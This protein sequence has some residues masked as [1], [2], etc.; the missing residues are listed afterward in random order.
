MKLLKILRTGILPLVLLLALLFAVPA[1]AEEAAT[2][3]EIAPET[4]VET[5]PAEEAILVLDGQEIV[6]ETKPKQFAAD[7]S[8]ASAPLSQELLD[9]FSDY[10]V[11]Y[12][13]SC[14]DYIDISSLNIRYSEDAKSQLNS[15]LWYETPRAFHI[16]S[17]GYSYSAGYFSRIYLW[18]YDYA[19]TFSEV[20]G[21]RQNMSELAKEMAKDVKDNDDLSDVEKA[22]ILHDRLA[23]HAE[24]DV[25]VNSNY[26]EDYPD[27]DF[28]A[29]GP[30]CLKV[31][32][33]QGY[34]MAYMYLLDYVGIKSQYCS[35]DAL[36][37]GWNIVYI[38]G[39][40]YHVDVTW[41][42]PI[43]DV[44]G[45]VCHDNF[46]RST[47][48]IKYTGHTA[49]DFISTPTSTKYDSAYWQNSHAAFQ[50]VAGSMYYFDSSYYELYMVQG[51][52]HTKVALDQ[53]WYYNT[54]LGVAEDMLIFNDYTTLYAYE[55]ITG[56]L[57]QFYTL[58][59]KNAYFEGFVCEGNQFTLATYDK[60]WREEI[61]IT[62]QLPDIAYKHGWVNGYYYENDVLVTNRWLEDNKGLQY[63][64]E[65]G[66]LA[67]SAWIRDEGGMRRVGA[68]GYALKNAWYTE[69]DNWYYLNRSGYK[70]VSDWVIVGQK[71]YYCD[72]NG[73]RVTGYYTIDGEEYLFG[74]DGAMI[75]KEDKAI[76]SH[77]KS[78]TVDTGTSVTF[79]VSTVGR[80]KSYRWQYRK[81]YTWFETSLE[82][83]NTATLTVP[84]LGSRNGYDY[85]CVVTF[86]DGT[87]LYSNPA[88]LIV[89]TYITITSHPN[90]QV[91]VVGY[92]GQFTVAAEGEGLKYQWE[93]RRP[94]GERW[95]ETAMEGANKP[96]VYIES[97]TARDGYQY[98]CRITDAAGLVT[99]S[100][101]ATLRSLF[102]TQQPAEVFTATGS[103]VQFAVEASV[104]SGFTYQWQ[105]RRSSSGA[106]TNTTM[107]G[108]NTNTLTV[109]ATKARNGYEYRCVLNG[110]KSS[111]IESKVAALH[112]G[113]P[114]T[115]TSYT[116]AITAAVGDTAIFKVEAKEAYSYQWHYCKKGGTVWSKTTMTG[117]TTNCL[118]VDVTKA[119]NGYQYK[120]EIKG[121]DG[122][123]YYSEPATLTVK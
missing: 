14:P 113:S 85:R 107:A 97:T 34:A 43:S 116:A 123:L 23:L 81:V 99:Y 11:S 45:R 109:D 18:Y 89:N 114:V 25:Y 92:K 46:L 96:T 105:Y 68:D 29:V 64:K 87:V 95:I 102:F 108:Y 1:M 36:N 75:D 27:T 19:D 57:Q 122:E 50:L 66:T 63:V 17:I 120:C 32:V 111:K 60:G 78:V 51:D 106:W 48:G 39:E 98:R 9:K 35:S 37:H 118:F 115:I 65:D 80:V 112:V 82:G 104:G 5:T 53:N 69:G 54:R 49:T 119:R 88:E 16:N 4:A 42:D 30:L 74:D 70:V 86:M 94:D 61:E 93:Y 90:D 12:S 31:G 22:L 62:I 7:K 76:V 2:T 38:D 15:E 10:V 40:P 55:P 8:L 44:L 84:A 83:Y 121:L 26:L 58:E 59:S 21:Y 52:T 41:D 117:A 101:A 103:K 79:S 33:C 72:K 91:S 67:V 3:P 47:D 110:A 24:Y 13:A 28:T 56:R 20:M 71:S 77:P 100:N 73:C 6:M